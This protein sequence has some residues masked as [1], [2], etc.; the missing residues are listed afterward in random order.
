V[1]AEPAVARPPARSRRDQALAATVLLGAAVEVVARPDLAWRPAALGLGCLLAGA[2]L[3][4]R[5]RPLAAVGLAFGAFVVLD[6]A[7]LAAGAEPVVL[8]SG[9]VVLV[10][11]HTLFRWGAGRDV[12]LGSGVAVLAF[13]V[14][15]V[16]DDTGP[17]EAVAGAAALLCAAA[18]GTATRYR[19]MAREHLVEQARFRER[20]QLARELHD[21]VAHH[22]SAIAIQAQAGLVLDRSS[23]PGG[24]TEA[25]EAIER[26]AASTLAEMRA[27]VGVLRSGPGRPPVVPQRRL[28]DI[29]GL[30][31]TGTGAPRVDVQ[32]CGDLTDLAPPVEAALYRVA[33]EAVT[34]ARRHALHATRVEVRVSGGATDVQ[35]TVHDD[36]ARNTANPGPPG[37]G[38]VGMTE[39][40]TLLGG[41]LSAGPAPERGW[42][43]RAVLPRP[44]SGT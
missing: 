27:I 6:L 3:V 25:L 22:V 44:R 10:L 34:N 36:G 9:L 33:Q 42:R 32:L 15:V 38:L 31:A 16:T 7:A 13:A 11:V 40:V 21:T 1:W 12:V 29:A 41:T 24:A 5:T 28:S 26:E 37:H 8:V 35:L 17:G 43:V 18:L 20:E 30:A 19:A 23:S 4:R 2:V 39:R 14:A